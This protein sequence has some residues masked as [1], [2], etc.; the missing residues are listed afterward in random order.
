MLI[1]VDS[2]IAEEDILLLFLREYEVYFVKGKYLWLNR[3]L[4][5]PL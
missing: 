3:K 5:N 4:M 2:V 1:E